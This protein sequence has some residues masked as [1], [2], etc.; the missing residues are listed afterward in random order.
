MRRSIALTSTPPTRSAPSRTQGARSNY[1]KSPTGEDGPAG[2]GVGRSRGGLT[3]KIHQV[4]DGHGLPLA[5]VVTGGQRNDGVMLK[6]TLEDI[7]VPRPTGRPRTTPEVVLA[8]RGYTSGVNRRYLR[9]RHIKMVIPQKKNEIAARQK[10]GSQ[11]GRPP[12]LDV[13]AY[14]G[15]NVVERSFNIVKQ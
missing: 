11:G 13:E 9:A 1:K 10:K 5:M 12:G 7:Y 3:T 14:K 2:H 8:D 6:D 4:V 15:R